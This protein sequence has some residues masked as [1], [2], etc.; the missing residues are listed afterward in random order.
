[1]K[2]SKE[3]NIYNIIIVI[4]IILLRLSLLVEDYFDEYNKK[5]SNISYQIITTYFE[6]TT[7]YGNDT[8]GL[9]KSYQELITK[10]NSSK[11]IQE[12]FS[13][14][15][16]DGK[17]VNQF[18]NDEFFESKNIIPIISGIEISDDKISII[19]NDNIAYVNLYSA[20]TGGLFIREYVNF[21]VIDKDIDDIEINMINNS[22]SYKT[23]MLLYV[24]ISLLLII[25]CLILKYKN[26]INNAVFISGIIVGLYFMSA[27]LYVNLLEVLH[28]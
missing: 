24:V 9:I 3:T 13:D 15:K 6:N 27:V 11:E 28:I 2:T 22:N 14:L 16:I 18:F 23:T 17:Q 20:G 10:E 8:L 5:K 7:F 25:V 12:I 1:M 4:L 21:I 19:K 26:K